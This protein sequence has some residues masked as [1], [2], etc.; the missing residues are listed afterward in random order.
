V[1]L[2]EL[3]ATRIAADPG[4]YARIRCGVY[5]PIAI[6]QR[7]DIAPTADIAMF[8]MDASAV[9]NKAVCLAARATEVINTRYHR[10]RSQPAHR[11]GNRAANESADACDENVHGEAEKINAD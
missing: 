7:V 10:V 6:G 2:H 4:Q 11:Q 9:Q 3:A 8:D 5:D 1:V